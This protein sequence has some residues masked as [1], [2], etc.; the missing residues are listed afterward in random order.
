MPGAHPV[1]VVLHASDSSLEALLRDVLGDVGFSLHG[2]G[3]AGVRPSVTLALVQR[4]DSVPRVLQAAGAQGAPV[5]VL[6][7]FDDERLARLAVRLGARGCFALGTPLEELKRLLKQ[8]LTH[9]A[10]ASE[11]ADCPGALAADV[12]GRHHD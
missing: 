4:G 8:V 7:P 10:A 1:Q 12:Q 3:Q 5:V 9:P 6:L 11:G 2:P